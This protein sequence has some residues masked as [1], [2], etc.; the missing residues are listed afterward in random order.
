MSHTGSRGWSLRVWTSYPRGVDL[1]GQLPRT[2]FELW[3]APVTI[4]ELVGFVTGALCVWLLARQHILNWP[5]AIINN[6]VFAG[7]YF[8]AQIYGDAGLQLCFAAMMIYGWISW[9]RGGP[10]HVRPVRQAT[11][12]EWSILA[13]VTPLGGLALAILLDRLTPSPVPYSDAA[14]VALSLAA[15]YGQAR[16]WLESWWIWIAVDVLAVPLFISRQLYPTALL[17]VIYGLL[18]L[19]GLRR[20]RGALVARVAQAPAV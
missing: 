19:D 3:G 2:A 15:S 6:L 20:W 13:I 14:V 5:I 7:V 4:G 10:G 9:T 8:R 11:R 17:Y 12:R 18:C 16:K 1:L